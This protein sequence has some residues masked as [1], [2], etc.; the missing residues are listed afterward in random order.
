MTPAFDALSRSVEYPPEELLAD[1][2]AANAFAEERKGE[3]YERTVKREGSKELDLKSELRGHPMGWF[4]EYFVRKYRPDLPKAMVRGMTA[5]A[6][7]VKKNEGELE[8]RKLVSTDDRG[9]DGVWSRG[10]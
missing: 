8:E 4:F 10:F 1:L 9:R 5:F 7:F 2:R 3:S 6:V